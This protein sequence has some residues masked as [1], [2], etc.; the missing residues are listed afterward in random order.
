MFS[1]SVA[2]GLN[3][4]SAATPCGMLRVGTT[5]AC[6]SVA[7]SCLF[8]GEDD[9][10]VVRQDDPSPAP[11]A[12]IASRISPALGFIVWPPRTTSAAPSDRNSS[13]MPAPAPMATTAMPFAGAAGS[14]CGE[15][16]ELRFHVLDLLVRDFA[17]RARVRESVVGRRGVDMDAHE[18]IA[19]HD[20]QAVAHAPRGASRIAVGIESPLP[21]TTNSVQNPD[22]APSS[23]MRRVAPSHDASIAPR[24]AAEPTAPRL[25]GRAPYRRAGS[26][27]PARRHRRRL[28]P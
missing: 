6:A 7:V 27:A 20:E 8:G 17:E 1:S 10:L 21:L 9:V 11:A 16:L 13:S 2:S 5:I 3:A 26:R 24:S 23:C 15:R 14:V 25:A 28:L 19:A 12:T 22:C 18:L 4:I